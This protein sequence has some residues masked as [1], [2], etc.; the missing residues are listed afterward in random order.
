MVSFGKSGSS[1]SGSSWS[2]PTRLDL[3][4]VNQKNIAEGL[5]SSIIAPY[6]GEEIPAYPQQLYTPRQGEEQN[7][8]DLVKAYGGSAPTSQAALENVLTGKNTPFISPEASSDYFSKSLLPLMRQSYETVAKPAA[9]EAFAGP[10]YWGR[11]RAL[12]EA[13]VAANETLQEQ[14]KATELMYQN[15]LMNWQAQ[16]AGANNIAAT[17]LP[18]VSGALESAGTAGEYAR[19]IKQEEVA[20]NFQRWLMGETVDGVTPVQYN[21]MIQLAF[22]YLGLQPFT[23]GQ[24]SGSKSSGSSSGFSFGILG[25]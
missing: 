25:K 17:A 8:F 21:P 18:A 4:D 9:R 13:G 2:K 16:M 12:A 22:Q 11:E 3:W 5:Y 23:Y 24:E 19:M 14:S 6:L 7:Y 1:Q 15:Q 20:A 10:G